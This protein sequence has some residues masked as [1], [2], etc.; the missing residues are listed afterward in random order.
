MMLSR[1]K[2]HNFLTVREYQMLLGFFC[3]YE[4]VIS[5][6][7]FVLKFQAVTRQMTTLGDTFL[8]HTVYYTVYQKIAPTL[9]W[10]SSKL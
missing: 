4:Q 9:K 5:V 1:K 10:Y 3:R 8:P 6:G 2:I 7:N